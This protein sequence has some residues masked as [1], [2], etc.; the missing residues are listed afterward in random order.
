MADTETPV[1]DDFRALDELIDH[2]FSEA[3]AR[4]EAPQGPADA[5]EPP[6]TDD[7][8]DETTEESDLEVD[9]DLDE[10][11][12][13]SGEEEP[14]E[15]EFDEEDEDEEEEEDEA[16]EKEEEEEDD[17]SDDDEGEDVLDSISAEELEEI[18]KDPT[19]RKVHKSMQRAFTKKTMDLA[20]KTRQVERKDARVQEFVDDVRTKEGMAGFLAHTLERHPEVVGAAFEAVA[21]GDTASAFLLEVGL[22]NPEVF[23]QAYDRL[24]ELLGD[25][26]ALNTHKRERQLRDRE[27]TIEERDKRLQRKN[28]DEDYDSLVD[29]VDSEAARL[30]IPEEDM[31]ELRSRLNAR[32]KGNVDDRGRI[33]V[34]PADAKAIVKEFREELDRLEQRV[35][36]RHNRKRAKETKEAV[37]RKARKGKAPRRQAPRGTRRKPPKEKTKFSPP[38]NA[39]PLDS[40][41]DHRLQ[42]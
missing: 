35:L 6:V 14:E 13:E 28:F 38:K 26:R 23:E 8:D 12:E 29:T 27:A 3:A 5:D 34:K 41:I 18:E 21:T 31:K 40:Y 17:P 10:E 19:L 24:H 36:Q 42:E 30:K 39:D 20:S 9:D 25:E 37:R 7:V 11:D 16:E 15:E 32:V 4:E 1:A 22:D 33:S 2:R